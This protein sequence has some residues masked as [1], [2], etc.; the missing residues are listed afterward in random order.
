MRKTWLF[1]N[2]K[3]KLTLKIVCYIH[4]LYEACTEFSFTSSLGLCLPNLFTVMNCGNYLGDTQKETQLFSLAQMRL[5][6]TTWHVRLRVQDASSCPSHQVCLYSSVSSFILKFL[7]SLFCLDPL[8]FFRFLL[9][10]SS[11]RSR[12]CC[13]SNSRRCSWSARVRLISCK[14]SL[15]NTPFSSFILRVCSSKHCLASYGKREASERSFWISTILKK[16]KEKKT[17]PDPPSNNSVCKQ[18]MNIIVDDV[19]YMK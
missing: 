8:S 4:V 2:L 5:I 12:L 1:C 6:Q 14:S 9:Y 7:W 19:K 18:L 17:D 10:C 3:Q 11:R 16:R 15:R 13:S